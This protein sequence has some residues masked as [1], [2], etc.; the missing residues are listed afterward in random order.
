MASKPLAVE[1]AIVATESHCTPDRT[2]LFA[3]CV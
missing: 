3:Q 2:Q 1:G